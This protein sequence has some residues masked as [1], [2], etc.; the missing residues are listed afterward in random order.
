M[1]N[2][3]SIIMILWTRDKV[4]HAEILPQFVG[5][6]AKG[7]ISKRVF[8]ENKARQIFRKTNMSYRLICT[9]GKKCLFFEKFGMLCFFET[10]GFRFAFLPYYQQI[11][12]KR[13]TI[14]LDN[15]ST[16]TTYLHYLT[17]DHFFFWINGHQLNPLSLLWTDVQ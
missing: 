3:R 16:E 5:N 13:A 15:N 4:P 17:H 2:V 11:G 7:Q 12:S 10:P 6:K 8:Q 9:E 1:K 14:L